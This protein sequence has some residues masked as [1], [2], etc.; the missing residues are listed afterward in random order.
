MLRVHA[1]LVVA[2]A[3]RTRCARADSDAVRWLRAATEMMKALTVLTVA[4]GLLSRWANAATPTVW[5][6]P[7]MRS[8]DL[9]DVFTKPEQWSTVRKQI[10]AFKLPVQSFQNGSVYLQQLESVDAM[11]K[12]S[13]MGTQLSIEAPSVKEW[14]CTAKVALAVTEAAI[15]ASK[16]GGGNGAAHIAMDEPLNSGMVRSTQ[17]VGSCTRHCHSPTSSAL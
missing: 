3:R 17:Y 2:P 9:L 16:A 8:D 10:Q 5:L 14:D 1:F 6:S 4:V 12:L 11:K 15:L 7:D 13:D